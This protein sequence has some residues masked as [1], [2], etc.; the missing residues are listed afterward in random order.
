M[1][2][3][4]NI[5]SRLQTPHLMKVLG[6]HPVV[7]LQGARQTGKTTICQFPEIGGSRRYWSLD[8]LD[9]LD[10][11]RREPEALFD[12]IDELTVDEVQRCPELLSTIKLEVDRD[13]RPGRFLLTGSANLLLSHKVSESLAGRA[14]YF[15]LPPLTWLEVEG[16]SSWTAPE[17]LLQASS[18]AEV[19]KRLPA[20]APGAGRP[21]TEAVLAGGY[22]VP[23]LSNDQD[24]RAR[25]FDGYVQTYL[26]RD[27][28]D[29]SAIENLIDFR[30]L[31]QVCTTQNGTLLNISFLG[32]AVGLKTPA[33]RRYLGLLEASFQILRIPA[34]AVNRG[35]RLVK[36]PRLYWSDTGLAAHLAGLSDLDSLTGG[37]DWGPWLEN[38]VA[39][40]LHAHATLQ[41]PRTLL[42]HWRTSHGQEV[43]FVLESGRRLLPIEVKAT[44]RPTGAD[45]SGLKLFLEGY[46]EADIGVVVCRC[47]EVR[48]LS[49]RIVAVPF[50]TL[51][52]V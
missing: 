42:S 15:H 25:W 18:V 28:R 30:R 49:K 8:E 13:R 43:D 4:H 10:L 29:L 46:P 11:A 23:S 32:R 3:L 16:R 22:P 38:W 26:E 34:F 6:N 12:G 2:N 24:F 37:R 33:T 40:H 27:L 17:I 47:D 44:R 35:K 9:V 14:V 19:L 1:N 41:A 39:I 36:S 51:L 52:L 7:V 5:L 21:L 48:P 50:E 20:A 45:L 31:M